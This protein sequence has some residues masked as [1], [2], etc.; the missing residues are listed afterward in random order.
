MSETTV[1]E[2]NGVKMEIDLRHARQVHANLRIG[3]R[4]KI[5]NKEYSSHT[6]YPG[7]IVGFENFQSLPTIVVAALVKDYS[8]ADIK[9]Y[10]VNGASKHEMVPALDWYPDT[11]KAEVL[12]TFNMQIKKLMLDIEEI[13]IKKAYFAE[14]FGEC[15][16]NEVKQ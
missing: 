2:I 1:I 11:N 14:H 16:G 3:S 5:L 12:N 4:V 9:Y 15:F 8:K 13:E 10:Y 7:V 6:I